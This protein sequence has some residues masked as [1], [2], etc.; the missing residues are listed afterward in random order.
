MTTSTPIDLP[1]GRSYHNCYCFQ[2]L[3][4][5]LGYRVRLLQSL[6][7]MVKVRLC[8]ASKSNFGLSFLIV[9]LHNLVLIISLHNSALINREVAG[10]LAV[11][12]D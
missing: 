5:C 11:P 2:Y 6:M 12:K 1:L 10:C 4:Y 9:S 3:N 8:N 7:E